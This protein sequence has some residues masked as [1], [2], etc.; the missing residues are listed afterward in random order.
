MRL[1]GHPI[2]PMLVAF[3]VALLALAPVWDGIAWLGVM[4]DAKLAGYLCLLGGLIGG[5]LAGLAF[6][7]A[8]RH[9]RP[10]ALGWAACAVIAAL[11][12]LGS[13]AVV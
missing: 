2:H 4:T 12:V 8:E 3:P 5:G 1:F 9:S 7:W 13:L 10:D 6:A 11:A